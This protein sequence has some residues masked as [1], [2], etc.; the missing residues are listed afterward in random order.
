AAPFRLPAAR[1]HHSCRHPPFRCC[2]AIFCENC[3]RHRCL[4]P[5]PVTPPGKAPLDPTRP[6]RVCNACYADV[7]ASQ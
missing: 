4:V 6:H 7:Q 3:S 1:A 5:Q 2:G